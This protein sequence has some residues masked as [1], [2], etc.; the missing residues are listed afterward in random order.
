MSPRV[1]FWGWHG[2][3]ALIC[4]V[5]LLGWP[6]A[7]R[8]LLLGALVLAYHLGLLASLAASGDHSGL[9]LWLF[10][11]PLSIFMV[12][13]DWWLVAQADVLRFIDHGLPRIGPVP[14]YMAGMWVIPLYVCLRLVEGRPAGAWWAA[15]FALLIFGAAEALAP[16]LGLWAPQNVAGLGGTALY[17]LPV[18][19]W[20]GGASYAAWQLVDG[21]GRALAIGTAA[22]LMLSYVGLAALSLMLLDPLLRALL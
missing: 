16:T 12:L 6:Q 11:L 8:G 19:T 22:G 7:D 20:L 9:R 21:R 3:Y 1:A 17:I 18:E 14:L 5:A 13:P 2:L 4:A 15:G 10:L